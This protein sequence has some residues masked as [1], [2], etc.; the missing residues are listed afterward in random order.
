[1][2]VLFTLLLLSILKQ[3]IGQRDSSI[4]KKIVD[5]IETYTGIMISEGPGGYFVNEKR[6]DKRTYDGYKRVMEKEDNCKP[7][8]FKEFNVEGEFVSEGLYYGPECRVGTF[9]EYY[10]LGGRKL[11]GQY[12]GLNSGNKEYPCS[13]KDGKWIYYDDGGKILR[14]EIYKDGKPVN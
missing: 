14:M 6:V 2:K 4:G 1:M 13:I 8:W 5:T 3:S 7:C 9:I 10:S 11:T 12:K